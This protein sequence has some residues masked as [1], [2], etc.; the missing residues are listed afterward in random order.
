MDN[1]YPKCPAPELALRKLRY[2][3]R[4]VHSR[5]RIRLS[6][7]VLGVVALVSG[8]LIFERGRSSD[9]F[10]TFE[11]G[12]YVGTISDPR[13]S[14]SSVALPMVVDVPALGEG[15]LLIMEEKGESGVVISP[16]NSSPE[17]SEPLHLNLAGGNRI[18]LIGSQEGDTFKGFGK[19]AS[20]P[21]LEWTLQRVA[22]QQTA[23]MPELATFLVQRAKLALIERQIEAAKA[24]VAKASDESS[25]LKRIGTPASDTQSPSFRD[26]TSQDRGLDPLAKEQS[27]IE[28]KRSELTQNIALLESVSPAARLSRAAYRTLDEQ[29]RWLDSALAGTSAPQISQEDTEA[30]KQGLEVDRL[31]RAIVAAQRRIDAVLRASDDVLGE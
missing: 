17:S 19:R 30:L 27:Q 10:P 13:P 3:S 29:S 23:N 18:S 24:G 22:K 26:R 8:F 15:L 14:G 2:W 31:Q 1:N 25:I 21:D 9:S 7:L 11:P 5:G 20:G 16:L 4:S 28:S 6:F 12:R